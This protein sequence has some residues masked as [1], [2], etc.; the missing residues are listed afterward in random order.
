M[1]D[2]TARWQYYD[3]TPLDEGGWLYAIAYK[4]VGNACEYHVGPE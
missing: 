3:A 4:C 2:G 1:R